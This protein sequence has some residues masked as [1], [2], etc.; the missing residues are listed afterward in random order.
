MRFLRGKQ[1]RCKYLRDSYRVFRRD[2]L[3]VPHLVSSAVFGGVQ[4]LIGAVKSLIN[5]AFQGPPD[6]RD[7]HADGQAEC[8]GAVFARSSFYGGADFFADENGVVYVGVVKQYDKFFA[9]E[10]CT[11]VTFADVVGE[12][13]GDVF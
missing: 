4:R 7:A 13:S 5:V 9:A 6:I 11:D 10:S 8:N 1:Y 12:E 3:A 2:F